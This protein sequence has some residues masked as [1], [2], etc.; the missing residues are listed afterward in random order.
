M[1]ITKHSIHSTQVQYVNGYCVVYTAEN[2]PP[3]PPTETTVS[4][5]GR[6]I[7]QDSVAD[8][9]TEHDTE[10]EGEEDQDEV[11]EDEGEV[12]HDSNLTPQQRARHAITGRGVTLSMLMADGMIEPGED[13]MSIEYLVCAYSLFV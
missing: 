12:K 5:E 13:N 7:R 4:E 9:E 10:H 6:R 3:A 1:I 2:A 11:D 8:A